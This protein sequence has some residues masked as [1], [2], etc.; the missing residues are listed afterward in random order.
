MRN[1]NRYIQVLKVVGVVLLAAAGGL[2]LGRFPFVAFAVAI[3]ALFCFLYIDFA[4]FMNASRNRFR[5]RR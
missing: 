1:W 4:K 5:N 2:Y 3:A